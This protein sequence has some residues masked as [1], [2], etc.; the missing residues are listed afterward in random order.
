MR[1]EL[2]RHAGSSVLL[3]LLYWA[4][5]SGTTSGPTLSCTAT[6]PSVLNRLAELRHRRGAARTA[7]HRAAPSVGAEQ[8]GGERVL[9]DRDAAAASPLRH[10]DR[11]V[12]VVARVVV[13]DD[14]VGVVVAAVQEDADQRLVVVSGGL[15]GRLAHGGQV[16][17][18]GQRG[19]GHRQLARSGA[20]RRGA[21]AL[22]IDAGTSRGLLTS[23]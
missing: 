13:G 11:A 18:E 22:G 4:R 7:G 5:V 19:A 20:G 16:E 17:G 21:C 10:A 23:G 8:R 9:G 14:G 6:L 1:E 3:L 15:R 12:G 2:G